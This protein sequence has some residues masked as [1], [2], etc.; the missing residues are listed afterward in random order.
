M[1]SLDINYLQLLKDNFKNYPV[2]IETGTCNGDTIFS[3]EPHFDML[4]TIELSQKYF[5]NTS[6]RYNGNK[7]N[8]IFGDSSHV[9]ETLLPNINQDAVFFL[10]GHWSSGDTAKGN[11]DCPLIEEIQHINILYK[12][13]AIIIIDDFRLFGKGPKIGG[14]NEDWTDITKEKICNILSSRITEIY[15]LDSTQARNDRLIIHITPKE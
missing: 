1:P 8:F 15:H 12:N 2:F 5:N 10:D 13:K 6:S 14:C 11:K 3:V 7:I 9:F 4:Y